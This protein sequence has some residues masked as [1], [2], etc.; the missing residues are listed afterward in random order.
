MNHHFMAITD[1]VG[2]TTIGA[3]VALGVLLTGFL[4]INRILGSR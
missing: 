4:I 2:V 1:Y 3:V